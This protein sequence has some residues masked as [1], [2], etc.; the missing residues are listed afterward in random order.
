MREDLPL[1]EVV[2]SMA[3]QAAFNDQRFSPL[4][5]DELAQVTI[6][7]SALTPYKPIKSEAEIILGRDGV[8]IRKSGKQAVFLPQV[9]TE[10]GW[11]KEELL[12]NLCRKAGLQA[13]DWKQGA[14]LSTFQ[15]EV[16][17]ESEFK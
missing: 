3:L 16:F 2:G 11:N 10:Q 12:D 4:S 8:V 6:E 15:A 7:I 5:K 14:Q 9:A 13:G 1:C 17:D